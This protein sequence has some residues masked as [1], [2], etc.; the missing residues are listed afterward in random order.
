M[1][2][3]L[4]HGTSVGWLAK[5]GFRKPVKAYGEMSDPHP[6]IFLCTEQGGAIKSANK[7]C[8][9]VATRSK[10]NASSL[11]SYNG[12]TYPIFPYIYQAIAANNARAIDFNDKMLSE[13][14]RK[15]VLK[16]IWLTCDRSTFMGKY[17]M[18]MAALDLWLTPSYWYFR[19]ESAYED[20]PRRLVRV[21]GR[22]GIDLIRNYERDGDGMGYGEVWVFTVTRP[23]RMTVI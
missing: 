9:Q 8:T 23:W 6:Y 12:V 7:A 2:P 19:L 11:Y 21:L 17:K 18:I 22:L 4:Y 1:I 10:I 5:S 13:K 3:K 20:K 16:A 15:L 14:D